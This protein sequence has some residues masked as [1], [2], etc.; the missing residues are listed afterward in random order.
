M[1]NVEETRR[2]EEGDHPEVDRAFDEHRGGQVPEEQDDD[3]Y[4]GPDPEEEAAGSG[5]DEDQGT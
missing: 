1:S 4:R 5:S 2:E 3:R